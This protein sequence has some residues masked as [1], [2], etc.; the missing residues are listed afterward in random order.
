MHTLLARRATGDCN[1][2]KLGDVGEIF[3]STGIRSGIPGVLGRKGRELI[4]LLLGGNKG[5]QKKDIKRAHEFWSR[6]LKE[7]NDDQA[8]QRLE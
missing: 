2:L 3:W 8:K 7:N 4:L 5:S 6:C 1:S